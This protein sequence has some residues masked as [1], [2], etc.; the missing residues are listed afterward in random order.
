[1][2]LFNNIQYGPLKVAQ[3]LALRSSCRG[4]VAGYRQTSSKI[5]QSYPVTIY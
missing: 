3:L 4:I 1:M 5:T 2:S